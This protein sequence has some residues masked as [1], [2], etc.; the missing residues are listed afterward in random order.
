MYFTRVLSMKFLFDSALSIVG[1][2]PRNG[3]PALVSF[4]L[5]AF[6]KTRTFV[7]KK[8]VSQTNQL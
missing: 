5:T 6:T 8:I 1:G 2:K 3:L 4:F 7:V